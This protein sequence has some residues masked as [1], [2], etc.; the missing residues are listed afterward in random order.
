MD[1]SNRDQLSAQSCYERGELLHMQKRHSDAA[2]WFQRALQSD[3]NHAQS[4]AMLAMCWMQHKST[5]SQSLDAAQR[6]V[7]LEPESGF[8]RSILALALEGT[9]KEG[10]YAI[11]EE[12]LRVAQ[13]AVGLD[14][15]SDFSYSVLAQS[16]LRVR[17]YAEAE[18]A[19]R[20]ALALNIDNTSAA[21]ILS[22]AL[23]QQHKDEDNAGLVRYQL[24]N[25]PEDDSSHTSA[26]LLALR[27]GDHKTANIH[28][29]EALRLNPMNEGARLGLIDSYRARSWIYGLFLRFAHFMNRFSDK[30]QTKIM[31]LGFI[32]YRIAHGMLNKTHP[33]LASLVLALW[34]TFALWSHLARSIGSFLM[35][36][37]KFAL[38]SLNRK[39][40][41]E[42]IVVGLTTTLAIGSLCYSYF[43]PTEKFQLVALAL[44]L[45]AT[46]SAAAFT[47]DH[48]IGKWIYSA[49]AFIACLASLSC[50]LI[51][52]MNMNVPFFGELFFSAVTIGVAVSWLRA[53]RVGYV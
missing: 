22:R 6:A 27:Q 10:Q 37:D 2:E 49:G 45:S 41:L 35:L 47:N 24:E 39:E 12:A 40:V 19:A 52:L 31:V 36:F 43:A 1:L 4:Y 30:N 11:F 33:F 26:G 8:F 13:E 3:A 32:G 38:R 51:E 50:F 53:L 48:Y 21:E 23:L 29:L 20:R 34:L 46:V 15:D 5:S 28:F 14:P 18:I 17:Q 42:G 9:A 44:L 16:H 25:N 7:S